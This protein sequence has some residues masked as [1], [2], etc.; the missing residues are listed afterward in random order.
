MFCLQP[1]ISDNEFS[2]YIRARLTEGVV[3]RP[4]NRIIKGVAVVL[5]TV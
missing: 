4:I 5:H 1:H 2:K 3:S